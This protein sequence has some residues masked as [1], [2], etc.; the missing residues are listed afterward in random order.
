MTARSVGRRASFLAC[1]M[2]LGYLTG[3]DQGSSTP[4]PAFPTPPAGK[5]A[6]EAAAGK[7]GPKTAVSSP[8]SNASQD[9]MR[10]GT[11][12]K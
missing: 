3:C 2:A 10:G 7:D 11:S 8:V 1:A 5:A 6:P 12:P 9:S 4:S